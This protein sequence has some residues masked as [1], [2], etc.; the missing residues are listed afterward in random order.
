MSW[1][2]DS[3]PVNNSDPDFDSEMTRKWVIFLMTIFVLAFS[4][5]NLSLNKNYDALIPSN[6]EIIEFITRSSNQSN[7]NN[8][9][10]TFG[11]RRIE[12]LKA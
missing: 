11:P 10:N 1:L 3:E 8:Q 5:Y 12:L 9:N 4:V 2:Y 7:E 6:G